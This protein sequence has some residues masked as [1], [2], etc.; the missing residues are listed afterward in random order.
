MC[1][2]T[3]GGNTIALFCTLVLWEPDTPLHLKPVNL[4]KWGMLWNLLEAIESNAYD[5]C[6]VFL[7]FGQIL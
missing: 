4:K 6:P 3:F 2:P 7:I 5:L 1:S